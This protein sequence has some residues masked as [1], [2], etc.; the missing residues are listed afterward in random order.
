V[1]REPRAIQ[2]RCQL[3]P[4]SVSLTFEL[5]RVLG[6][7]RLVPLARR[8]ESY[9]VRSKNNNVPNILSASASGRSG[10]ATRNPVFVLPEAKDLNIVGSRTTPYSL[11][12]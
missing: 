7:G 11:L 10:D 8:H 12:R 4:G 1:L 5:T 9:V 2:L 3:C 6:G